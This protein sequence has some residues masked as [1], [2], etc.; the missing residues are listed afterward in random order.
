M[1]GKEEYFF[2]I[3]H[4]SI[5]VKEGI[6]G[7]TEQGISPGHLYLGLQKNSDNELLFGK[8]PEE[9][10]LLFGKAKIETKKEERKHEKV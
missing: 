10:N 6:T 2:N 3:H 1:K 8:Y 9:G 7:E 5:D 4:R